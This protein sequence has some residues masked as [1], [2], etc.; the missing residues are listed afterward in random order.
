VRGLLLLIVLAGCVGAREP[1]EL[2]APPA[3]KVREPGGLT[4]IATGGDM[5]LQDPATC[6][7][8]HV[9]E[10]EEWAGSRHGQAW[11][12]GIFRREYR[13]QPRQ[14]CVNCHA[15]T[16][17]QVAAVAT[18]G[19]DAPLARHGVSCAAC[20]VRDGRLISR[21]RGPKSP[22]ATIADPS[23]GGPAFCGDCHQ[24]TF[25]RLDRGGEPVGMSPH[26]MQDTVAQFARSPYAGTTECLDCHASPGGHAFAGAHSAP[27]LSRALAARV[28]RDGGRLRVELE[29][30]GAGHNLPTGDV[31]RHIVARLW[32]PTAPESLFEIFIGRRYE[33]D[34]AGG[35]ITTWDSTLAPR[36][37][38]AFSVALAK[39]GGEPEEPLRFEVR[40]VY[41]ADERPS[42]QDDPGEPTVATVVSELFDLESLPGCR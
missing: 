33:D 26:P 5:D 15:P 40:Y 7:P 6:R 4:A 3:W 36:Q 29:N 16:E 23:F 14:W 38:R 19:D 13:E 30:R 18:Q 27:M 34:P 22:H 42:R 24:F 25:P 11:N 21:S 2:A 31:H 9:A 37:K 35:K 17:A 28:C 39:L 1:S 41:T 32:R 12:N 8:C 10:H 20:H